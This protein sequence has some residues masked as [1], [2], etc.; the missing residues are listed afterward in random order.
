MNLSRQNMARRCWA[1]LLVGC[2]LL[3]ITGTAAAAE[4][5]TVRRL[6]DDLF[7]AG[8]DVALRDA[9]PGD[10]ALAGQNVDVKAEI[11]GDTMVA[12]RRVALG[13]AIRGDLYAA[14]DRVRLNG[15]VGDSARIAGRMVSIGP[16]AAIEGGATLAGSNVAI[17]GR[18]GRYATIAAASTQ[19][20]GRIDGDLDVSGGELVLGPQAV[21]QGRL[22][23]RGRQPAQIAPG[24][25]VK[26]GI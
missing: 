14:G 6:G 8:R 19:V 13:A 25:Q 23:Y 22:H 17:D 10:A 11:G 4:A 2:A 16:A 24:A 3:V 1:A 18:I 9:T 20:N 26:G 15:A 5:P 7:I 21:V 12:G